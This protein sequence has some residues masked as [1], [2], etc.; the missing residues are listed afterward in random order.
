[1]VVLSI[2]GIIVALIIAYMA[3]QAFNRHSMKKYKYEIFNSATFILSFLGYVA[4]FFGYDW[5]TSAVA[6]HGDLL[7]GELLM[8][9]GI[10]FLL[11]VLFI[12]IVNTSL[13]YGLIMRVVV[14]LFYLVATPPLLIFII[15]GIAY[16]SETKPVISI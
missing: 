5:Y 14:E 1:M 3:I 8:S 11:L 4:I 12:N 13:F 7:N 15:L 9:I 6:E 16:F 2:V 10:I